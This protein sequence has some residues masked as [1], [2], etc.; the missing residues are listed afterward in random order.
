MIIIDLPR[1]SSGVPASIISR[2][3]RNGRPRTSSNA[4]LGSKRG[5]FNN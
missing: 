1:S 3:V 2:P 5:K 4:S